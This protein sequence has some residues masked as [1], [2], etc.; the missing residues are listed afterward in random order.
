[1]KRIQETPFV[2]H[3]GSGWCDRANIASTALGSMQDQTV[4][5]QTVNQLQAWCDRKGLDTVIHPITKC[6]IFL[7]DL[8]SDMVAKK[9]K[10]PFGTIRVARKALSKIRCDTNYS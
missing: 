1:L 10:D 2:Q 6:V 5:V 7:K 4:C 8:L 9:S 3:C